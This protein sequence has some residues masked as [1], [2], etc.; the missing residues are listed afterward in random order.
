MNRR[1][2]LRRAPNP[3]KKRPRRS[4][5]AV[6][7]HFMLCLWC[8]YVERRLRAA[9]PAG[10]QEGDQRQGAEA[11]A[12]ASGALASPVLGE[13][14]ESPELPEEPEPVSAM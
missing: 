2:R 13:V 7:E 14:S 5:K 4:G 8:A 9:H 11:E 3:H 12:H 6:Q 1:T 10:N